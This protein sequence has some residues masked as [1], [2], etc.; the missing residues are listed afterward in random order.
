M[1]FTKEERILLLAR[2]QTSTE[3]LVWNFN[4]NSAHLRP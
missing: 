1:V 4:M 2:C 3:E